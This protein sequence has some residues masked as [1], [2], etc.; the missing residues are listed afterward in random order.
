MYF[1]EDPSDRLAKP[2]FKN[3]MRVTNFKWEDVNMKGLLLTIN[4]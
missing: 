2:V 3:G 1:R 4:L